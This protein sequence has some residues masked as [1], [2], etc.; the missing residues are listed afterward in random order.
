MK[1]PHGVSAPGAAVEWFLVAQ[2]S[3]LPV[4]ILGTTLSSGRNGKGLPVSLFVKPIIAWEG[5][6]SRQAAP[7]PASAPSSSALG[8]SSAHICTPDKVLVTSA[9]GG[10]LVNVSDPSA[11]FSGRGRVGG[12]GVRGDVEG[13]SYA[14]RRRMMDAL[15]S[16]D[17]RQVKAVF[18]GTCTACLLYTSP[19]PRD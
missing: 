19:S 13:F 8:L 5:G 16:V 18:F 4:Y 2:H 6:A 1:R 12:G 3:T 14:S 17:R 7:L 15:S 11:A 9:Q 10:A